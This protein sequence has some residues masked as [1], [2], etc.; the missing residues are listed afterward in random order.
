MIESERTARESPFQTPANHAHFQV[1][2]R[3]YGR[4]LRAGVRN[5]SYRLLHPF[6]RGFYEYWSLLIHERNRFI[7]G[8]AASRIFAPPTEGRLGS[9]PMSASR[10]Y[11][12]ISFCPS[13]VR[14]SSHFLLSLPLSISLPLV[15][16]SNLFHIPCLPEPK[17]LDVTLS[18][19]ALSLF[20]RGR[21]ALALD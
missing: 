2:V 12:G 15:P 14:S 17:C 7:A 18:L 13:S 21:T 3:F 16:D 19:A 1:R 9:T 20:S 10:S 6:L 5:D 11:M 4:Q 8:S